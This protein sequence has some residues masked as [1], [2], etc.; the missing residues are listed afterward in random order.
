MTPHLKWNSPLTAVPS[1]SSQ[2]RAAK[3]QERLT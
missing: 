3:E 2:S 1:D